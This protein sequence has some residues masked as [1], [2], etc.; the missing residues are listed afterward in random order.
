M[1]F[2]RAQSRIWCSK[3]GWQTVPGSVWKR[4]F[5]CTLN[6]SKVIFVTFDLNCGLHAVSV[7]NHL[8][9]CEI[10][11]WF[12]YFRTESEPIFGFPHNPIWDTRSRVRRCLLLYWTSGFGARQEETVMSLALYPSSMGYGLLLQWIVH[13]P[14]LV[15]TVCFKNQTHVTFSNTP[16]RNQQFMVNIINWP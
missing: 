8:N 11:G 1:T 3:I 4:S 5:V 6:V 15:N 9:G 10:F 12:V 13:L 16:R 14:I 2:E 7:G